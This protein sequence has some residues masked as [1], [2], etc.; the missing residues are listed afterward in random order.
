[1]TVHIAVV[2]QR[3]TQT[4]I[5][6][7]ITD[8]SSLRTLGLGFVFDEVVDDVGDGLSAGSRPALE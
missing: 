4:V 3:Q 2:L 6:I 1:M 7:S 5:V 8:T